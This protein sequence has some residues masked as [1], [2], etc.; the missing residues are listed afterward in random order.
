MERLNTARQEPTDRR[1]ARGDESRKSII[2][3]AID[4]I[5]HLGLNATTIETVA[6]RASVSR[7]LV[8]FH[9]KSKNR[10]HAAVLNHIGSQF[11]QGWEE[12]LARAD[13][14]ARQRLLALLDYDVRFALAH[15]RHLAVWQA[16]WGEARGSTLYR[17]IEFPRDQR[18][19][20]DM[21]ALLL[22]LAEEGGVDKADVAVLIKGLEAL[23]FGLWWQAH[24][25]PQPDHEAVGIRAV[26]TYLAAAWPRHFAAR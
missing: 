7:S 16:F 4:S 21:H 2:E 12:I 15:P 20:N 1:R 11:S 6:E 25:S 18:Y 5:A 19:M 26:R 17:E 23:L 3:A 10:L 13:M 14:P 9:F 24:I 8:L 22:T